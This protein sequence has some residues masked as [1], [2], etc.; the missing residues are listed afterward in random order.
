LD[1]T[2]YLRIL[3]ENLLRLVLE[4]FKRK[5]LPLHIGFVDLADAFNSIPHNVIRHALMKLGYPVNFVNLIMLI[6]EQSEASFVNSEH[7][8]S[9]GLRS[10]VKQGC[11]F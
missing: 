2:E 3:F 4:H 9:F 11:P 1:E 6:H 7:S 5:K 10:G 8:N